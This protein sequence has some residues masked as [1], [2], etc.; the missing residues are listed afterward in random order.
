M[1]ARA[2]GSPKSPGE[3]LPL[4]G[5]TQS[6]PEPTGT[7][8]ALTLR[9]GVAQRQGCGILGEKPSGG[10]GSGARGE[11]SGHGESRAEAETLPGA[12]DLGGRRVQSRVGGPLSQARPHPPNDQSQARGGPIGSR[13]P[14][15]DPGQGEF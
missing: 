5:G 10:R 4:S 9:F 7:A 3:R 14:L 6:V 8:S 11:G 13:P 12:P 15:I 2:R 1:P